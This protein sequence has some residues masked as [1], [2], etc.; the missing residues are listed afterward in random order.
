MFYFSAIVSFVTL[1][2]CQMNREI[3]VNLITKVSYTF[4]HVNI[5]SEVI[6]SI[7]CVAFIFKIIPN[8]IAMKILV[9]AVPVIG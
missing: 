7:T 6:F 1:T 2:D 8:N 3:N 5:I 4:Y 9:Q